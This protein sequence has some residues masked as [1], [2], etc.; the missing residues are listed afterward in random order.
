MEDFEPESTFLVDI[1]LWDLGGREIR[2][3][4]LTQVATYI[5]AIGGSVFDEYV[6][7][8]IT[9]ARAEISGTIL[10]TLLSLEDI[11]SIDRP[12]EPDLLNRDAYDLVLEDLPPVGPGPDDLPVIGVID[13][14]VNDHPLLTDILIGAIGVPESLGTADVFGH[15][16]RV[17]GIA[18]YGDLRAQLAAGM[19]SRGA[20]LC[21]AKVVNDRE[22]LRQP[23]PGTLADARGNHDSER[24]VWVSDF[25]PRSGDVETI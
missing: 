18:V 3:R 12:P 5:V 6:G 7:P 19:L 1:E 13:T 22:G 23:H 2:H 9:M 20:R 4:R 15:G 16:T 14:G 10:R 8:S 11:A 21:S 24:A 17:G 25:C